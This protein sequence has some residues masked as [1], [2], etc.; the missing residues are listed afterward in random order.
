MEDYIKDEQPMEQQYN[1][2]QQPVQGETLPNAVASM[3]LGILS[4]VLGCSP[5][6]ILSLIHI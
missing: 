4:I 6:G 3:V 1:N 2:Y 5:V